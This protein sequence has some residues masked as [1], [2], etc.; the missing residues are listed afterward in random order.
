MIAQDRM[1]Q[2]LTRIAE[3]DEDAATKFA[4]VKGQRRMR[5]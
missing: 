5:R 1:E 3:S 2:A 4:T